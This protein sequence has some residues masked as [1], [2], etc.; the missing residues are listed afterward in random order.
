MKRA[1]KPR[2][3]GRGRPRNVALQRR[4]PAA[5]RNAS[6]DDEPPR[7]Y[8]PHNVTGHPGKMR[9]PTALDPNKPAPAPD[10][11]EVILVVADD[12]SVAG[13][14]MAPTPHLDALR[15][16]GAFF[17]NVRI[18]G[19]DRLGVCAPSRAS[20]LTGRHAFDAYNFRGGKITVSFSRWVAL[21]ERLR[22]AGY[23]TAMVGKWHADTS[24]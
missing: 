15:V 11:R 10:S 3:A 1:F 16:D 21:P 13:W 7:R 6:D 20:L 2:M 5:E 22:T 12:L 4:G 14:D 18:S 19:S 8:T 24:T 23:A 17:R 9:L